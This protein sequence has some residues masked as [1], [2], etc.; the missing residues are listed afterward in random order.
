MKIDE[1]IKQQCPEGVEYVKVGDIC[2][3]VSGSPV[4]QENID[5][6]P[7]KYPVLN[8]GKTPMGYIGEWNSEGIPLGISNKGS[9]GIVTWNK[10]R[11]FRGPSNYGIQPKSKKETLP[12]FL[13]HF[14][15]KNYENIFNMANNHYGIPFM[16]KP[17]IEMIQ[18]PA[19]P[20][21]PAGDS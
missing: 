5:E 18:V 10:E 12:R 11:V 4:S 21:S 2:N 8:G 16:N 7:G 6:N 17:M 14:M 20:I 13:Y 9:V 19:P 15:V 1:L 3:V